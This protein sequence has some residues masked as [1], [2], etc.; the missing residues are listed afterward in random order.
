MRN[1]CSQMA[2]AAA[3]ARAHASREFANDPD[4]G[5][6]HTALMMSQFAAMYQSVRESHVR[7]DD[8]FDGA[9]GRRLECGGTFY[10]WA[11]STHSRTHARTHAQKTQTQSN[12][13]HLERFLRERRRLSSRRS[14]RS[15]KLYMQHPAKNQRRVPRPRFIHRCCPMK[16]TVIAIAAFSALR[17]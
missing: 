10:V 4:L 12:Q 5:L 15:R 16:T 11:Q 17:M 7:H 2:Q 3:D 1:S 6:A 8:Q 13:T 9:P 14:S